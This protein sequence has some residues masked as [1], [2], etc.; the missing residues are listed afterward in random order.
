MSFAQG[1]HLWT[2]SHYEEFEK[3]T[4]QGVEIT[5]EG[6][7]LRG[8]E[9]KE[10]ATTPSSFVWAVAEGKNGEVYAATGTPATVLR[11]GRDGKS[12]KIFETKALA[13]QALKVGPDGALYAATM[14]DGKV[15]R[16]KADAVSPE[17]ESSAEVV[18][19]LGNADSEAKDG[20]KGKDGAKESKSHYIWD[21]T[22]DRA[23]RL[24]V[25]TGGP[26]TVYRIDVA[27]SA[28]NEQNPQ[29]FFHCDEQHVRS[30]AW[31]KDGNL[32][33]GTDGSGLVYRISPEGKGY[34]LY[35]A[36]RREITALAVGAD[37]TI[38]AADVGDKSHNPLPQLPVQ[39]GIGITIS[40]V[41]P[42]SMQAA[43][44]STALPEGTE[45]YAL[46]PNEA[47]RKLWSGKDEV[48]YQLATDGND[49]LAV[50]GN[51]GRIFRIHKDGSFSDVAHLGAQLVVALTQADGGW[52]I[53]TGNTGK[54][55]RLNTASTAGAA[56]EHTYASD[57]LDASAMTRWGRVEVDPESH[58]YQIWTRSGNVEQ[59]ARNEKDWGWSDWQPL[60]A[61]KVGSP[62]GRYLQ[63]KAELEPGGAVSGVGVNFLPVNSAPV[64]D[65]MVVV[66]GARVVPQGQ[67]G[68]Q[69]PTVQIAFPSQQANSGVINY[70]GNNSNAAPMQAQKD[71]TAVTVR[72]A[73]HDDDGDDL[74]FN[75]YLM[76]DGEHV[77]RPL[78]KKLTDKVYSFDGSDFPDGGYRIKVVAT[79][80]PSHAPGQALTGDKISDRFELDTTPP[81]ITALKAGAAEKTTD[82]GKNVCKATIAVSFDAHD[83]MSPISHAEYSVD[84]GPWQ[85]IDPVG[86]LSDSKEEHYEFKAPVP[87]SNDSDDA[88]GVEH[89]IT[90]RAYDRH[91]N[92]ATAKVMVPAGS[93]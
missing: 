54:V 29:P 88:A 59:P 15:Y 24:Y 45:I 78:K 61:G 16:L 38:Y 79:D 1:T 9:A 75:L 36:P 25:A 27:Q 30:L 72:W 17:N 53:G 11:I 33:A 92:M 12:T 70:D 48:V 86:Q 81:E 71:R 23:G 26:A 68:G 85:Y 18:F 80:A 20:D 77:W 67:P 19:D 93:R 8:P 60:Q 87:G 6:R 58:G 41:Q 56:A 65:E 69:P 63:W 21:L 76:G 2:Q 34:V 13:V 74:V 91:D 7:L 89:L 14:P 83:A 55:Y 73:A 50:T 32:I 39:A 47:P 22:F 62:A 64:V 66:P 90:V 5:S 57:V 51:R 44:A 10:V 84:A 46:T 43:N 28:K 40:F 3:G 82:C 4:P 35:S 37:G 49:L 42:G 31:D 52:L